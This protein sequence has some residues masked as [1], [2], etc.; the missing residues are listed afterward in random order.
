[1]KAQ[2]IEIGGRSV[3]DVVLEPDYLGL[4]EVVVVAYGTTT[5][6][7]YTGA[8]SVVKSDKLAKNPTTSV[9]KALQANASGVQVVSTSGASDAEPTIRIRGIGS[10]TA[11]ANPLWVVDGIVGAQRPHVNDIETVTVLKDAAASSLYGSRAANGVIVVTTK[12]GSTSGKTKFTYMGKRS[13][14]TLATNNFEM[15]EADEFYQKSWEGI[16]NY[17]SQQAADD[18]T[19]LATQGV[20]SAADYAHANIV[21]LAGRNPFSIDDP[22]DDN[23]NIKPGAELMIN[24]SWFDISHETGIIDEHTL[25]ASGG[26]EDTQFY[27]SGTYYNQKAITIPDEIERLMGFMSVESKVNDRVK[28]GF[29]SRMSYNW[30]NTVKNITNGSGTGYAAYTYPNNVPLYQ[31]DE[32]FQ[33]VI[34]SD[35]KPEWNWDNLVSKDYNPI[36][37][38]EL[39]P[40]AQ[41]ESRIFTSAFLNWEFIDGL[42]FRYQDQRSVVQPEYRLF[43]E[44]LSRGCQ[45]LWR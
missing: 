1:M 4:E 8:A 17:A 31:L 37:Q 14:Q 35:G 29:N 45:S 6:A 33:Q 16:Y 24:N 43:P 9:V 19:W 13:Y 11:D 20:A 25:T 23:G 41:R 21:S 5:K 44:S 38:T 18:P 12:K 27:F 10:I 28:V 36:A 7:S 15:L 39:D 2:V 22:I 3:I 26:N 42:V 30:G 40:R 34:G 32:N